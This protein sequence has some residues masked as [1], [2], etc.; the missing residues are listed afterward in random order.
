MF[1]HIQQS[2]TVYWCHVEHCYQAIT[3]KCSI[4]TPSLWVAMFCM[5]LRFWF[6]PV[7]CSRFCWVSI[8]YYGA[9]LGSS[10]VSRKLR[11]GFFHCFCGI[12]IC[13]A[14]VLHL[15]HIWFSHAVRFK[16]LQNSGFIFVFSSTFFA[17]VCF[18]R[19]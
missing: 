4:H 13:S 10:S 16:C 12:Y 3:S 9:V 15:W 5:W 2:F 17:T 6:L 11:W 18:G 1:W 14:E 7:L 19:E 8:F